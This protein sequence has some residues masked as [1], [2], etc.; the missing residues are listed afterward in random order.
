MKRLVVCGATGKQGG[1]L[2]EAM[3]DLGGWELCAFSRDINSDGA[4][5]LK[6]RGIEVARAD[7]ED[8]DSLIQVFKGADCVFGVTQ[9]WN[10]AYT[11]CDTQSEL[12][13]GKNIVDACKK[14]DVGHLVLST[15][16][17]M[18]DE[19]IGLPHVDIKIDIELYAKENEAPVTFLK[20]AQFMDNVGMKFLPVKK[21]K[22]RGFIDG[23]AKVPYVATKDIGIFARA[24]FE[25]PEKYI[26]KEVKL[27]G[28]FVSGHD[29][30]GMM[31]KIRAEKFKYS[32]V[33]KWV[34]WL[35]SR[36][37]Y[38]MRIAFEEF[39]RSE[40]AD[41]LPSEIE[42]CRQ[43]DPDLLS[44]GKYLLAKNWDSRIL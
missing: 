8:L 12:K 40:A 36:E 28:D 10:K 34:I 26:G 5:N 35:Y 22:I 13:Q 2:V 27:I 20:P 19:K 38:V 42:K 41:L 29:L 7:L 3:K 44:M 30:A 18:T 6:S 1:S 11:K 17:H 16:A 24:A 15:A 4:K 43:I 25:N 9:P 39:A 33:P 21:G 23:D 14:V 31:S 32:A 37:F